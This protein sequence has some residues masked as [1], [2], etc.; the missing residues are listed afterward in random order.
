MLLGRGLWGFR[1]SLVEVAAGDSACPFAFVLALGFAVAI[2]LELE[3]L[4]PARF[5]LPSLLGAM[6]YLLLTPW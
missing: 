3:L 6:V 2:E 5:V 1:G 4:S